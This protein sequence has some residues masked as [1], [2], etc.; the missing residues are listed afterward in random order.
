[1]LESTAELLIRGLENKHTVTKSLTSLI[2]K[3]LK[4]LLIIVQVKLYK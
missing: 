2:D 3:P 1:M 4:S